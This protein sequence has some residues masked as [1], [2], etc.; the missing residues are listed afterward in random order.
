M[1]VQDRDWY[2]EVLRKR[3]GLSPEGKRGRGRK[4]QNK[5]PVVLVV[6]L[7]ALVGSIYLGFDWIAANPEAWRFTR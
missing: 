5:W 2:R 6:C 7:V 4:R 3:Q 1:G